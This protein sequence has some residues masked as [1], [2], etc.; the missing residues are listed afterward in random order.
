[1]NGIDISNKICLVD[2]A[3]TIKEMREET[4]ICKICKIK[5]CPNKSRENDERH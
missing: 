4:G 2:E 3:F 1:M 5:D